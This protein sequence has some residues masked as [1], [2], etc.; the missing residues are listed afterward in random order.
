VSWREE[1]RDEVL[2]EPGLTFAERCWF[3]ILPVVSISVMK[4]SSDSRNFGWV[5]RVELFNN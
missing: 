5:R 2:N 1:I 4:I 3:E